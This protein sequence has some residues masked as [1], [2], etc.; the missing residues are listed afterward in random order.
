MHLGVAGMNRVI[1][2][3]FDD[4]HRG[5]QRQQ[6]SPAVVSAGVQLPP[7]RPTSGPPAV[8]SALPEGDEYDAGDMDDI[9]TSS[10]KGSK[11]FGSLEF[12]YEQA[13][14]G[15]QSERY[16][17]ALQDNSKLARQ[18]RS[19][20]DELAI[21][22][23]KKEAFKAQAQ[24]LER[25]FR[26]GREQS[27]VLQRDLLEA[28]REAGQMSKEAQD[29]LDMMT[30]MRKAHMMEVRLLQRGLN[31]GSNEQTRNRVNEMADLIDKVGRAV[32]QRDEALREKTK[33][34]A[35]L[36]KAIN[37]LRQCSDECGR[38]RK[39]NKHL[40]E[41]LK[42]ARRKGQFAPPR[43]A[44]DAPDDSDEE[45][46]S[47]LQLFERRFEI[48]EEGPAGLDVLASNLSKDKQALEKR[49]QAQ[50]DTIRSLNETIESWKQLGAQKDQQIR[51]LGKKLE[52][53]MKDMALMEEQIA[54][55]QREIADQVAE[56]KAALEKRV[57]ELELEC[58]NAR[59]AADGME[60]ASTRLTRELVKVHEQMAGAPPPPAATQ[61]G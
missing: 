1:S 43:A 48:L 6:S 49:V 35:Q 10:M 33:A 12:S 32:L 20:Q 5:L 59:A 41:S 24:R 13:A 15:V 8:G 45:F 30:E 3:Y 57:S 7:L 61:K 22:S 18:V 55:K 27:D 44:G 2:G 52:K 51:D 34:A 46:E 37:D 38:L 29:A 50:Q 25:E 36:T 11:P 56:E 23:A 16:Q 19:L 47:E 40:S 53:V 58:D 54:S 4:A 26:R 42:E 39:Q 9:M 60:K 17:Q 28:R 14:R 31:R 21:T